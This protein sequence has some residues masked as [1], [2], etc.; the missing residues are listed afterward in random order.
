MFTVLLGAALL[1]LAADPGILIERR[2]AEDLRAAV[3][4]TVVA[5]VTGGEV[6]RS[7]V[8]EGIFEREADPNRIARNEYEVRFH[9]P[10]LE[11]LLPT[12]DRVDRFAV[13]L[14]AGADA[15]D[16][17]RWVESL[18]YGTEVYEAAALADQSSTTFLVVSRFH[19]A[20]GLVTMLASGIFLLCLMVIRVDERR[21]DIRT[22][23]LVGISRRTIVSAIVAEAIVVATIASAL[24]IALGAGMAW[25]VNA[26]FGRFYD[27]TLRFAILTPRI[28]LISVSAGILLGVAAGGLAALRI[29]RVPPQ[30]LGE[31]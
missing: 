27:T 11:A 21:G 1:Q 3:G 18:A 24:G 15:G 2:L 30:R 4:D 9:L 17:A 12:S 26:Y 20:I 14:R 10:D 16:V 29:V 31:R 28:V 5:R 6:E 19:D 13:S 7:F 22:M 23:R 8:V 25:G